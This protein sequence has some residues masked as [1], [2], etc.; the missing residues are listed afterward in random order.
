MSFLDYL[1]SQESMARLVGD[2]VCTLIAFWIV[3]GILHLIEARRT[4]RLIISQND[5]RDEIAMFRHKTERA[6]QEKKARG[7]E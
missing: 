6:E 4:E 1:L 5:L 2:F 3:L 7:F